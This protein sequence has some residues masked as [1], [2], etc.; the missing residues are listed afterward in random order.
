MRGWRIETRCLACRYPEALPQN[1][2]R[3]WHRVYNASATARNQA[4]HVPPAAANT[5]GPET[6]VI[7]MRTILTA[8]MIV[9]AS[10]SV[11]YAQAQPD[12][13]LQDAQA[14]RSQAMRSGDGAGWG[15]YTTDDFMVVGADG[16]VKTKAERISEINATKSSPPAAQ[17]TQPD[18][19]WR[20]YG[21]TAIA[22]TQTSVADKPTMITS[23]WVKQQGMWKV[24]TVQLT[25]VT[26]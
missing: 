13:A 7:A 21:T 9:L 17:P 1:V 24:A 12:K 23:V 26:K 16:A 6:E 22:T 15:K 14:A 8:A 4:Y 5:R 11:S 2:R 3:S 25:N 18:T 10:A 19:K 20:V